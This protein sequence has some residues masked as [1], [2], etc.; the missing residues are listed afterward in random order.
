MQEAKGKKLFGSKNTAAALRYLAGRTRPL[1]ADAPH[2]PNRKSRARQNLSVWWG[3][4]CQETGSQSH[5]LPP[6]LAASRAKTLGGGPL[7]AD[8]ENKKGS[9]GLVPGIWWITCKGMPFVLDLPFWKLPREPGERAQSASGAFF[10]PLPIS[11]KQAFYGK[12]SKLQLSSTSLVFLRLPPFPKGLAGSVNTFR[13]QSKLWC[14]PQCV[15]LLANVLPTAAQWKASR[16][17]VRAA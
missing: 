13:P 16:S 11:I 1:P 15:P 12:L 3:T 9:G 6:L 17:S 10:H 5:H 14:K 4:D 2:F 7:K 8:A